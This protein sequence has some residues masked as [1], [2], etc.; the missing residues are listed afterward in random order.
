MLITCQL[1]W[2]CVYNSKLNTTWNQHFYFSI[3]SSSFVLECLSCYKTQCVLPLHC[4]LCCCDLLTVLLCWC[5][6]TTVGAVCY[7]SET[8][9]CNVYPLQM[10]TAL[11]IPLGAIYWCSW[12]FRNTCTA[13]TP[14]WGLQLVTDTFIKGAVYARSFSSNWIMYFKN[15]SVQSEHSGQN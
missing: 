13:A 12:G 2:S 9:L 6:V 3:T 10:L 15:I 1:L 7:R 4:W 14:R 5:Y 11:L 8:L